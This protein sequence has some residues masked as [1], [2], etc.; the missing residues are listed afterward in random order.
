MIYAIGDIHGQV[1]MLRRLLAKLNA[2]PLR[3]EDQ[4]VFIGDYIDRGE[5]SRAVIEML[6]EVQEQCPNTIFLR[7]NHEQLLLDAHN[8]APFEEDPDTGD[9]MFSDNMLLWLQNGGT[10]TLD[11]Y[12]GESL[13]AEALMCWWERIPE[14]HWQ[15]FRETRMEYNVGPYLFVHAGILPQGASW[16][17]GH[18]S[19]LDPRLWIREPFLSSRDD[20]GGRIVVF[21]HTP[22]D[23]PLVH[24]NKVGIDTGAVFGG[25]L[26]AA[27]FN[28][29]ASGRKIQAPQFHHVEYAVDLG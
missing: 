29:K 20:F 18:H 16:G 9:L 23:K 3:E 7:G 11:S 8:G 24:R 19:A 1:T 13:D 17:V 14:S 15:F 4:L 10:E 25:R 6:L 22:Q 12:T 26:T 2:L 28:S 21:G 27:G 5:D